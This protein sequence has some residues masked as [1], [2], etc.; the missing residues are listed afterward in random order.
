LSS[1]G[2]IA[3]AVGASGPRQVGYAMHAL[4]AGT[5]VPWHRVLNAQGRISL[6]GEA[7]DEQ[8]QR[9]AAEGVLPGPGGRYDL[10]QR[11]W[12]APLAMPSRVANRLHTV[13][14]K[15]QK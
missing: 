12:T 2:A 9:L 10:L 1:Y 5:A 8:R 4:G 11:G 14:L 7:G 3:R 13:P 15:K 6:P